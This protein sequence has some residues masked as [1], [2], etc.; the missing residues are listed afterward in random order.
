MEWREVTPKGEGPTPR[1][2]HSM[3]EYDGALYLFG[4]TDS[5]SNYHNMYKYDIDQN[6]WSFVPQRGDIPQG[7]GYF[8]WVRH[9]S[10]AWCIY[11]SAWHGYLG[12]ISDDILSFDFETLT[13][14]RLDLSMAGGLGWMSHQNI[15]SPRF[16]HVAACIGD[17]IL[18]YGGWNI[19]ESVPVYYDDLYCFDTGTLFVV[20]V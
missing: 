16:A 2:G 20:I 7:R 8:P 5:V 4:G 14:V 12:E 3:L 11:G 19:V 9:G 17:H 15:P 6:E 10:H 13:W 18:L 1:E